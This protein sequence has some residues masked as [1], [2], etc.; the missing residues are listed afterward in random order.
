M[1]QTPPPRAAAQMEPSC[2]EDLGDHYTQTSRSA[3]WNISALMRIIRLQV[4]L[5]FIVFVQ[6]LIRNSYPHWLN[7]EQ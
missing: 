2:L 1:T 4:G 7:G 6:R 5:L 3:V